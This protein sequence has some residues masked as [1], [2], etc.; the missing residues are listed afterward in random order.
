[1]AE[2]RF[3][4]GWTD[5]ELE[6]RL[7]RLKG[8]GRNFAAEPGTLTPAQGWHRYYSE[9]L[10]SREPPGG[11]AQEGAFARA[12]VAVRNYEFSD[13]RIVTA[14]FDAR[15]P[16]PG[17]RM[18]LE[19][20][21]FGVRYL[22]GVE[23]GEVVSEDDEEQT[24]FGF[25]YDTLEGHIERGS[26]WF[27]LTQCKRTGELRFRIEA[28][29][30]PGDLPNWWSK[31]GFRILAPLYQRRWCDLAQHRMACLARHGDFRPPRPAKGGLMHGGPDVIFRAERPSDTWSAELAGAAAAGAAAG[32]RSMMPGAVLSR[33]GASP[34]DG[35][36]APGAASSEFAST[37]VSRGL[38]LAAVGECVADK[39]PI[40]PDRVAPLPLAGR[41]V[42]GSL[43]GAVISTRL[44]RSGLAGATVGAL[45]AFAFAHAGY[46]A[47]TA[48]VKRSGWPDAA[49]AL[50]EDAV[51]LGLARRAARALGA[52]SEKSI[53]NEQT[54]R[55][56]DEHAQG[57]PAR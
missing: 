9:A 5:R 40:T 44:G 38:T 33:H 25:R 20:R 8:A 12:R 30:R 31:A 24:R 27:V 56:E 45:A 18:L 22:C 39:L 54:W 51:A 36:V 32:L 19:I 28:I 50:V 15:L 42:A 53:H 10:L 37:V 17:R 23:V 57:V 46:R 47:R 34:A 52:G 7:A 3:G 41:L 26:E 2:W 55:P 21:A 4:R 29:W 11:P 35:S 6:N 43:C 1:V 49:V 14:H 13:P 16:L 48:L